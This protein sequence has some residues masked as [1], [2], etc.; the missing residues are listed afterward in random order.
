LSAFALCFVFG[1]IKQGC[2]AAE[3]AAH[4]GEPSS[5]PGQH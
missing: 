4:H 1:Q 3:R 2:D 5:R